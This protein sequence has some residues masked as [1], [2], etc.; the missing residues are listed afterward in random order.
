MVIIV[1]TFDFMLISEHNG[2]AGPNWQ[3]FNEH[4]FITMW[5]LSFYMFEGVGSVLPVMEASTQKNNFGILLA[6]ALATLLVV[7][8][9][10]STLCYYAYGDDLKEPIIIQQMP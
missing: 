5:G 10:F 2:E 9:Y 4:G 1:S 3:P 6:S 7:D 8:I